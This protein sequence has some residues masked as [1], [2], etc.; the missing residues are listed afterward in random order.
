[1]NIL[2]V[3]ILC[4]MPVE[5]LEIICSSVFKTYHYDNINKLDLILPDEIT[6]KFGYTSIKLLAERGTKVR[7]LTTS[8]IKEKYFQENTENLT[9]KD[10]KQYQRQSL[11]AKT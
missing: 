8:S 4:V 11:C 9:I 5:I 2:Q 10:V 3:T 6:G 7:F 1:M